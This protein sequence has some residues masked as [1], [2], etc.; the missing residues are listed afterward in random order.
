MILFRR[1][2]KMNLILITCFTVLFLLPTSM[3]YIRSNLRSITG[4]ME[5]EIEHRANMTF[6]ES[7]NYTEPDF[8]NKEDRLKLEDESILK[9]V[10]YRLVMKFN[11]EYF[12]DAEDTDYLQL[13]GDELR[14]DIRGF[15][16]GERA[17]IKGRFYNEDDF[18]N[19][20][21][22]II[23]N[24]E[25]AKKNK[26]DIGDKISLQYDSK[27]I[28]DAMQKESFEIIGIYKDNVFNDMRDNFYDKKIIAFSPL[29][30]LSDIL[31]DNSL[32]SD[33]SYYLKDKNDYNKFREMALKNDIKPD[34]V[35]FHTIE[36]SMDNINMIKSIYFSSTVLL[37]FVAFIELGIVFM[38]QK[39]MLSEKNEEI[40]IL[41]Y[42]GSTIKGV[43]AIELIENTF[44][45]IYG[46]IAGVLLWKFVGSSLS[47]LFGWG[48]NSKIYSFNNIWAGMLSVLISGIVF[49]IKFTIDARKNIFHN[50]G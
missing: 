18:L 7:A 39:K 36:Y 41:Y 19:K 29:D 24:E 8:M 16:N 30:T 23:I 4:Y 31:G 32:V 34:Q 49:N 47:S 22:V 42:S 10:D 6:D 44:M 11:T 9:E 20:R 38:I 15:R 46:T 43:L 40:R 21:R 45:M 26:I 25:Y 2:N 17:L 50:L 27:N 1:N 28:N 37:F 35:I 48:I 3:R 13:I 5:T 14:E 12:E 33:I